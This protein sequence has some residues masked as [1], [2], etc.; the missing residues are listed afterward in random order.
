M[1]RARQRLGP[2]LAAQSGILREDVAQEYP[3]LAGARSRDSSSPVTFRIPDREPSPRAT[4][5]DGESVT[6]DVGT[7]VEVNENRRAQRS[8]WRASGARSAPLEG[9]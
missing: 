2:A 6:L 1:W 3:S 8:P 9:T 5:E 4:F 7:P